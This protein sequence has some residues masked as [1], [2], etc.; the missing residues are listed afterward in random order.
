MGLCGFWHVHTCWCDSGVMVRMGTSGSSP[1]LVSLR[2]LKLGDW[3]V[4]SG[5][6]SW[7]PRVVDLERGA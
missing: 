1:F 2:F 6:R 5:R 7:D 4:N 3:D